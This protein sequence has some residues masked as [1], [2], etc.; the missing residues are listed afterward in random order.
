VGL[1]RPAP[2]IYQQ[3]LKVNLIHNRYENSN[4]NY[5]YLELIASQQQHSSHVQLGHNFADWLFLHSSGGQS[6]SAHFIC[7]KISSISQ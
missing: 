6:Q 1:T 3:S 4:G 5:D 2:T 7:I